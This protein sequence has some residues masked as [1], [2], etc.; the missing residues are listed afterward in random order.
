[1]QKSSGSP[2]KNKL[3]IQPFPYM[4]N[5]ASGKTS[6]IRL[7]TLGKQDLTHRVSDA[8]RGPAEHEDGH[9]DE[10]D[11]RRAALLLLQRPAKGRTVRALN[12]AKLQFR[13]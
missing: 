5:A 7:E 12:E 8:G 1:M 4:F 13:C 3:T 6:F 10:H 11:Q 9:R 2:V